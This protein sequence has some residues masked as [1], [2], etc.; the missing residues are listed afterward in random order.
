MSNSQQIDRNL[1]IAKTIRQQLGGH[2]LSVMT[3]A[4]SFVAIERGLQFRIGRNAKRVNV[5]RIVLDPSDT[6]TVSFL[7]VTRNGAQTRYEAKDIYAEQ[8]R[9]LFERETGM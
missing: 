5:V 6:Y 9:E 2:R 4:K 7:W 8:L 1:E 3:G